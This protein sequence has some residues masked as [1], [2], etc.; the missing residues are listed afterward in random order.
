[1]RSRELM[2]SNEFGVGVLGFGTV[3]AG[4]VETLLA[5][6]DLIEERTGVRPVLRRVADLDITTDRGVA[7]DP[8]LLT[9]DAFAVIDDPR[10]DI[11]VE[12]VGGLTAAKA[13]ILKALALGKPVITA[14]K[15]LLA[16]DGHELYEAAARSK[17]DLYYEASVAGG[18]PVIKALRE[19]LVANHISAIYG[20]LNGT[21]NYILTRMEQEPLVFDQ[22]L[23]EA[24]QAGYAE[25]EPSLDIDG[26]DAAHKA[27]LLASLAFGRDVTIYDMYIEGIRDLDP[28]DIGYA[29]ELGYRIKHLAVIKEVDGAIE[30][31]VEPALIP[32]AHV[33]AEV[34]SVYNAIMVVGDVVGRTLYYGRGAGRYPTASAVIADVVEV[35]RNLS[36]RSAGRLP[37][38]TRR[39]TPLPLR[40]VQ[41]TSGRF[42]VRLSLLD[43]PGTLAQVTRVLGEHGISIG[44]M[45]QKEQEAGAYVPVI[46]LTHLAREDKIVAALNEIAA[47]DAADEHFVR[48]V[49]ED[50]A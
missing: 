27:C 11:I 2:S 26:L 43:Q 13:L 28:A 7:V 36:M 1:M 29:A 35:A 30:I 44:A 16:E 19:G 48:F 45:I 14:N 40:P 41:E 32:H 3:G 21:C 49:V 50:H 6:A 5:K 23:R 10:I 39:T 22:V 47:L 8:D 31:R 17:A 15:A 20:I 18:I 4:V 24:Q 34:D 33:L 38:R 42:Y 46:F 37:A 12:L 9:T 25:A